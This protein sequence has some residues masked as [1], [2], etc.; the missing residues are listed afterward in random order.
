MKFLFQAIVLV[1]V[2]VISSGVAQYVGEIIP[3]T[4][5]QRLATFLENN[6][7][8]VEMLN[9][10]DSKIGRRLVTANSNWILLVYWPVACIVTSVL[11]RV[12]RTPVVLVLGV[13]ALLL[14]IQLKL[15]EMNARYFGEFSSAF[16]RPI[17]GVGFS[18]GSIV[19][20]FILCFAVSAVITLYR[21]RVPSISE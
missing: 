15:M 13:I 3:G 16:G 7:G 11:A 5:T 10:L 4:P 18:W 14:I 12:L 9:K 17:F 19:S 20:S 6:S 21:R 2:F 8:G 1:A